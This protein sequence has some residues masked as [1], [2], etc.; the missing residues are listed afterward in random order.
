LTEARADIRRDVDSSLLERERSLRLRLSQKSAAQFKLLNREH[1][2][3]QAD[4]V[5]KEIASISEEYDLLETQIRASSPRSAALTQPQ[6][7]SL[8]EIQQQVLDPETLLLEYS[9][10]EDSSYLFIVS[11]DSINSYQAAEKSRDRKRHPSIAGV[12]DR[13]ATETGRGCFSASD[14]DQRG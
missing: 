10:G 11:S 4:A 14:S 9:L 7:L 3:E 2:T 5:A 13:A 6:P 1:A 12:S 8:T